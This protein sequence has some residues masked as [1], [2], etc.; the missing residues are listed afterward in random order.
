MNR[1]P[2]K[3]LGTKQESAAFIADMARG[4]RGIA[5]D[6]DFPFLKYLLDM[7]AEEGVHLAKRERK[8]RNQ[9]PQPARDP[10]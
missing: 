6:A 8:H 9:S 7:V 5:D 3:K 2:V 1:M 10:R 4:L